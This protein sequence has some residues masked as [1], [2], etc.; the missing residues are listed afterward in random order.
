MFSG[1][2]NFNM[3]ELLGMAREFYIMKS[4]VYYFLT[5]FCVTSHF[6]RLMCLYS[7]GSWVRAEHPDLGPQQR[8]KGYDWCRCDMWSMHVP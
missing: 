2:A 4:S 1:I 5:S 6:T 3:L 7:L 8:S